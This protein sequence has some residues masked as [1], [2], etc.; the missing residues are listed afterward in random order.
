MFSANVE[1]SFATFKLHVCII[2]V[3]NLNVNHVFCRKEMK[4]VGMAVVFDA[5]KKP[6]HPEFAKALLMLQVA[7][8]FFGLKL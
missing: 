2:S 6:P 8:C 1:I 5:R 3:S 7:V 4:D